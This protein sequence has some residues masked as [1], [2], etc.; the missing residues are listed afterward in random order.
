RTS[1]TPTA[2]G[3]LAWAAIAAATSSGPAGSGGGANDSGNGGWHSATAPSAAV[4]VAPPAASATASGAESPWSPCR[5]AKEATQPGNRSAE[6]STH[7]VPPLPATIF[8]TRCLIVLTD[9]AYVPFRAPGA[10]AP[11]PP[12]QAGKPLNALDRSR[13]RPGPAPSAGRAARPGWRRG[14]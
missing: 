5:W 8:T 1:R 10:T 12:D 4:N 11:A 7:L 13:R 3:A 14:R 9:R 2:R 6:T